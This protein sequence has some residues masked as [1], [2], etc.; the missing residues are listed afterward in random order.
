QREL[1]VYLVVSY[2][3]QWPVEYLEKG[4]R[5]MQKY[6]FEQLYNEIPGFI[7]RDHII[8]ANS[9]EDALQKFT[10][11]HELELPA[12]WDEPTFDRTMDLSFKREADAVRYRITW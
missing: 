4:V 11:K 10:R 9:L 2:L 3:L 8:P 12:Y 6:R 1:L 7:E 5:S